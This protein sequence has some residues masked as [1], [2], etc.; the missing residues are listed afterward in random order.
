M[1]ITTYNVNG[2]GSWLPRII[3][4]LENES[5]DVACLRG[6]QGASDPAPARIEIATEGLAS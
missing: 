2:M 4:G 6:Q 5:A 3:E 1:K